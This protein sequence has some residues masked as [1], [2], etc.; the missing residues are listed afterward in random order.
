VDL[1][2]NLEPGAIALQV[3]CQIVWVVFR[4]FLFQSIDFLSREANG[5]AAAVILTISWASGLI[6][7]ILM[8]VAYVM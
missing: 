5:G 3:K 8:R 4:R 7:N 1:L 2:L 6:R